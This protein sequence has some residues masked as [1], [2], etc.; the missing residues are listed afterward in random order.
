[1]KTLISSLA[2]TGLLA[3]AACKTTST[4]NVIYPSVHPGGRPAAEQVH[5]RIYKP[6][7][8]GPFPA[9]LVLHGCDG[10]KQHYEGWAEVA[11]SWG[12]VAVL[13]DSFTGRGFGQICTNTADVQPDER[14]LDIVGTTAYLKTLPYVKADAIGLFGFSHGGW[15]IM[16]GVQA[17]A[18]LTNS[19]VKAAVAYYPW[20]DPERDGN[21]DLPL[22]ILMG[23]ADNWTPPERCRNL[24]DQRRLRKPELVDMVF[25][26]GAYHAFDIP[27]RTMEM[28]GRGE[29]G[30]IT[31][32]RVGYNAPAAIDAMK[33]AKAFFDTH[34][35]P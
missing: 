20:C 2:L 8:A 17:N 16:K 34:L 18:R 6:E 29:G 32:R 12:Y 30:S 22:L 11:A 3:L 9:I 13:V 25:Y 28:L 4:Q 24:K 1:M 31:M 15:T 21:V 14:V 27:G 26:D 10:I 7:G 5:A 35:K 19:G 33:R 23:A